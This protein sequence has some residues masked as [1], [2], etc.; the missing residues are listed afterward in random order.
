MAD[1]Q[2]AGL[3]VV[4]YTIYKELIKIEVVGS[5]YYIYLAKASTRMI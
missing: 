4:I 1:M 5:Y 3:G 2:D